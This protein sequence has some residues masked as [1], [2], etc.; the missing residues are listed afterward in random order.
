MP[1]QRLKFR[2]GALVELKDVPNYCFKILGFHKSPEGTIYYTELGMVKESDLKR[3][4]NKA[5]PLMTRW[6]GNP[7]PCPTAMTIK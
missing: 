4:T 5:I 2:V 1:G 6:I 3:A 7:G